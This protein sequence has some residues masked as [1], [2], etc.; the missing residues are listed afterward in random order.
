MIQLLSNHFGDILVLLILGAVV[1][2]ILARMI[3]GKGKHS[4]CGSCQGCSRS[5]PCHQE[6][7]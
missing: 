2:G 1:G 6:Q 7:D 3:R 4:C 5:C